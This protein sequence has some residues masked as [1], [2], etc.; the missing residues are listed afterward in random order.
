MGAVLRGRDEDLGRDLAIKVLLARH[1]DR[2]EM[3]H[4]FIEEA[5]V[6]GQFQ[7][8][9]IVLVDELARAQALCSTAV[10]QGRAARTTEERTEAER[11]A[12]AAVKT[13]SQAVAAGY[14]NLPWIQR[15][16]DLDPLRSRDD[17]KGLVSELERAQAISE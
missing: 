8:S 16:P 6:E 7:H 4:Q 5:Q 3:V 1:R 9:G 2:P 15:D 17:F 14:R 12:A 13:L 11:Y 10:G